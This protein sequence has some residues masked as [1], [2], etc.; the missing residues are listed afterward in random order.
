MI[1]FVAGL[2]SKY[3]M[4]NWALA[5][6]AM[7]SGTNFLTGI[8]IARYL[9]LEEFGRFTLAWMTVTFFCSLQ[10]AV[11]VSPM[12]SIAPKQSSRELVYYWGAVFLQQVVWV[13]ASA[14]ML[15]SLLW[16][17]VGVF[18]QWEIKGIISPLVF[19]L[20][21]FQIQDF[22]RRYFFSTLRPHLAFLN[23][24]VSYLGQL[25]V[26]IV[27]FQYTEPSTPDVLWVIAISSFVAAGIAL[28]SVRPF[29]FSR[30]VV[31]KVVSQHWKFSRW[32]LASALLQW[33]SGYN[34]FLAVAGIM[35]GAMEVGAIKAAQNIIGLANILFMA[36]ENFVPGRAAKIFIGE[37]MVGLIKYLKK[38]AVGGGLATGVLAIVAIFFA[39]TLMGLL[40]G[41]KYAIYSDLLQWFGVIYM[42]IFFSLPIGAGLRALEKTQSLF[43]SL[44]WMTGFSVLSVY[45]LIE[46]MGIYGVMLGIIVVRSGVLLILFNDFG[47]QAEIC[48]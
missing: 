13:V 8:L 36:M 26:L 17:S 10:F 28:F 19:A 12:M 37:G 20:I 27:L 48:R 40:Y 38:I 2:F 46:W 4:A 7:V 43:T 34:F 15:L 21:A 41:E 6:Q 23:D 35:L 31:I 25:G 47:R 9:G 33:T 5:D 22:F 30:R 16:V 42:L 39:D 18:P 45:P 11:I 32:L 14:L 3:R 24:S 44:L 29:K 1:A